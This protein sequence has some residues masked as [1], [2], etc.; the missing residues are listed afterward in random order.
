MEPRGIRNNNPLN[1][2]YS[3]K[4]NWKGKITENKQ[5]QK[6]EEFVSMQWGFRAAFILIYN[7]IYKLNKKNI[8]DVISSWAPASDNNNTRLYIKTVSE[9]IGYSKDDPL[10]F[11]DGV[12]VVGMVQEMARVETGKYFELPIVMA[13]YCLACHS[14]GK[15]PCFGG[16]EQWRNTYNMVEQLEIKCG[17][18]KD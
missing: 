16:F 6:F 3:E 5:D 13:G 18:I 4:N 8:S 7:Y 15:T 14:L 10:I 17:D 11:M 9:R 2:R 12:V 1:I